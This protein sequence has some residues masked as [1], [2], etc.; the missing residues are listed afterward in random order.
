MKVKRV[1]GLLKL[2]FKTDQEVYNV[3]GFDFPHCGCNNRQHLLNSWK[4]FKKFLIKGHYSGV[5][6]LPED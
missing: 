6:L 4:R 3:L 5:K 1:K 2:F